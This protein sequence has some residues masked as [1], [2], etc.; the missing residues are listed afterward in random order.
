MAY[1]LSELLHGE[2]YDDTQFIR[3]ALETNHDSAYYFGY[4][5][6][7]VERRSFSQSTYKILSFSRHPGGTTNTQLANQDEDLLH[8]EDGWIHI[9]EGV[10]HPKIVGVLGN[11]VRLRPEAFL[12]HLELEKA[13]P[14][15]ARASFELPTLPSMRQNSMHVRMVAL[16]RLNKARTGNIAQRRKIADL[17]TEQ[18]E[19]DI[20][21][22]NRG[23]GVTRIRKVNVHTAL[24][25]SVE[26]LTTFVICEHEN[27]WTGMSFMTVKNRSF[28]LSFGTCRYIFARPWF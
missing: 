16:G 2:P 9:V 8:V 22:G 1:R 25:F 24:H 7:Y 5:S 4:L 28:R 3:D 21:F 11:L 18:L 17:H 10:L 20:L 13:G 27:T 6:R 23:S 15:N 26:Y 19:E 12:G 14:L